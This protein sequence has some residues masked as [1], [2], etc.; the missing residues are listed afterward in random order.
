LLAAGSAAIPSTPGARL[1][2]YAGVST[3]GRE[4]D[5]EPDALQKYGVA[6]SLIF[7]DK[8]SGAIREC[9]AGNSKAFAF[10]A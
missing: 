3:G 8:A 7:T 5:R 10:P 1:T 4:L 6:K 2:G 9:Q